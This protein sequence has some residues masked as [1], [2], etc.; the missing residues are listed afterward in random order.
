VS[1][2]LRARKANSRD[3]ELMPKP[4]IIGGEMFFPGQPKAGIPHFKGQRFSIP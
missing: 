1:F 2:I 3:V 4:L